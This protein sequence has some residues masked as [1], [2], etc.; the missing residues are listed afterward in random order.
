MWYPSQEQQQQHSWYG[1]V[2]H[3]SSQ[4]QQI[5]SRT[6]Y[7]CNDDELSTNVVGTNDENESPIHCQTKYN[8]NMHGK[9]KDAIE[10]Q[11]FFFPFSSRTI[12][13][14]L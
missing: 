13:F 12:L 10:I 1:Y 9:K 14:L 3:P 8:G 6:S 7:Y 4:Q 5:Y 2:H 11:K